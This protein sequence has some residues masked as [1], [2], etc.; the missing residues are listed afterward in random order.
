MIE[1]T[2]SDDITAEQDGETVSIA[3][4]VHDIRDLGGL[5]FVIVRDREGQ[6]QVVFKEGD[7]E[8]LFEA[9]NDLGKEDES[10]GR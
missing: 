8:D 10:P 5:S 7:D 1:R 6:T 2:Y 4:H 9:S 3:G